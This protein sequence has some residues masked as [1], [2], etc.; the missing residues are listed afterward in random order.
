MF[1]SS[2]I[3]NDAIIYIRGGNEYS[4]MYRYLSSFFSSDDIE[5]IIF[6]INKTVTGECDKFLYTKQESERIVCIQKDICKFIKMGIFESVD[7]IIDILVNDVDDDHDCNIFTYL[8][9]DGLSKDIK[10]GKTFN[11]KKRE[12]DLRCANPRLSIIACVK[13]D[14]E[15]CLHDKFSDKRISGEWF[16]LSSNDVD[17]IINEYGFVL[18]E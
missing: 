9:V 1:G 17:N 5:R 18:I 16:S 3:S 10:I 12:R 6:A 11:V 7:D 15:R 8:A 13:G 2:D 4:D 14:I